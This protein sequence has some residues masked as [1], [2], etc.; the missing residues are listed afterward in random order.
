MNEGWIVKN[1][2]VWSVGNTGLLENKEYLDANI[3]VPEPTIFGV[4]LVKTFD[5]FNFDY[6]VYGVE[7][8]F[9]NRVVKTY[10]FST[11]NLGIL[12]NGYKGTG[13]TVTAKLICNALNLPVIILKTTDNGVIEFI[14]SIRQDIVIFID[15]YEKVFSQGSSLLTIMDGVET[16][17]FRRVFILTTNS[18]S[19]ENN[20]IDRPSRIRYLK[21]YENIEPSVIKEVVDDLLVNKEHEVDTI[22]YICSL[23]LVTIDIIKAVIIEVN[24]HDE[25]P[26][27]FEDVFNALKIKNMF[28]VTLF[29]D[30]TS[31]ILLSQT[32]VS[33]NPSF[34][35]VNDSVYFNNEYF[36]SVKKVLG[37]NK[38][39]VLIRF[40]VDRYGD[41]V[42]DDVKGE[43]IVISINETNGF[44]NTF[45]GDEIF[46]DKLKNKPIVLNKELIDFLNKINPSFTNYKLADNTDED[47]DDEF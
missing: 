27:E 33:T 4:N 37:N 14:N 35:R 38:F 7:S 32:V 31:A 29:K 23:A 15:E 6:K 24:I 19:I 22:N 2:D 44:N 39:E 8:A 10:K 20:L 13:K 41:V 46:A 1:N 21:R 47:S 25:P 40:N 36:G 17:E 30:N 9:I 45:I 26:S 12:L 5:R 42:G 34:L 28:K 43:N 16:S 11:D 3:Y 18:L